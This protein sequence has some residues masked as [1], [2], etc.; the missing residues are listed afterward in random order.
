MDDRLEFVTRLGIGSSLILLIGLM[1]IA[2]CRRQSAATQ[3]WLGVWTCIALLILPLAVALLPSW[4]A[5]ILGLSVHV[6]NSGPNP[7]FSTIEPAAV[8]LHQ[9]GN[10]PRSTEVA[11]SPPEDRMYSEV[12]STFLGQA[13]GENFIAQQL[14][15]RA[16]TI[17]QA[18]TRTSITLAKPVAQSLLLAYLL[19][20]GLGILRLFLAHNAVRKWIYRSV[21]ISSEATRIVEECHGAMGL[22]RR[23]AVRQSRQIAVPVVVGLLHP[24]ILLPK[25]A[26]CW[27]DDRLRAALTHELSHVQRGDL[28]TQ[29]VIQIVTLIYWPQPLVH[30]L[31]LGLRTRREV[32]CDDRVIEC[33]RSPIQYARHLLE[34]AAELNGKQSSHVA[35]LAMARAN[36]IESRIMVILSS[37]RRR[38]PPTRKVVVVMGSLTILGTLVM[39]SASP[40]AF[41]AAHGLNY[42][43]AA[44]QGSS[45]NKARHTVRGRVMLGKNRPAAG[46]RIRN[47]P[48][49]ESYPKTETKA[50]VNGYYELELPAARYHPPLIAELDGLSG[51]AEVSVDS[52][53]QFRSAEIDAT[54]IVIKAG[55]RIE[56]EVV[57]ET[58]LPVNQAAVYLQA[59]AGV[60]ERLE[61]DAEGKVAFV[62]PEGLRLQTLG[63][64]KSGIGCD[65]YPFEKF[66]VA[67][68]GPL[69]LPKQPQGFEGKIRL[70]L[71]GTREATVKLNG[72]NG[73]PL[74]GVL[75]HPGYSSRRDRDS[76]WVLPWLPEFARETDENGIGRFDMFSIHENGGV[77]VAP[78][79]E[80]KNLYVI[81]NSQGADSAIINWEDGALA[82]IQLAEKILIGGNTR[83]VDGRPAAGIAIRAAGDS[84]N[85]RRFHERVVSDEHGKW[86]MWVKPN[87]YYLFAVHHEEF[88]AVPHSGIVIGE[89]N[90]PKNFD[91]ELQPA[92]RVFGRIPGPPGDLRVILQQ[93]AKKHSS[94]PKHERLPNLEKMNRPITTMIEDSQQLDR[95]GS[96]EFQVGPGDFTILSPGREPHHF[97]ITDQPAVDLGELRR[98]PPHPLGFQSPAELAAQAFESDESLQR[99]FTMLSRQARESNQQLLIIAGAAANQ[100]TVDL[101]GLLKDREVQLALASYRQLP[102]DLAGDDNALSRKFLQT[103]LG[104]EIDTHDTELIVLGND[105]K[106]VA[107]SSISQWQSN[108]DVLRQT[109]IEF[110]HKHQSVVQRTMTIFI[111]DE[112]GK[113]LAN[114]QVFRNHVFE[115]EKD[116][117]HIEDLRLRSDADGKVIVPLSGTS[118]D[119]RLWV[120]LDGFVPLHAMWAKKFQIDGDQVPKEFT[121]RM[122]PGTEIG[123][124]VVN[125]NGQ[126]ISGAI[127][128]VEEPAAGSLAFGLGRDAPALRPVRSSW[129]AAGDTAVATD[130]DGRWLLR[131]VPSDE[132]LNAPELLPSQRPQVPWLTVRV[133]LPGQE[134]EESGF[135]RL[136]REQDISHASLR[137]RSAKFVVSTHDESQ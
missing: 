10:S 3:Y 82:E 64:V 125:E 42:S 75:L 124:I 127:V 122:Q 9:P 48:S 21:R 120:T 79:L 93:H 25:S 51:I 135:G 118:V 40:I 58:Q 72:P 105:Q 130:A 99:R 74:A 28:C 20:L 108:G 86:Q 55:R 126:P 16:P 36:P 50:D 113:P 115:F 54:A 97:A 73:E 89:S 70:L 57:D 87:G 81:G 98:P 18:F 45:E 26:S 8:P 129:L 68:Q 80:S 101:Y 131:N 30:F 22:T 100:S 94:L 32:A 27:P 134:K 71:D 31:S 66:S 65:Y 132:Q 110:A 13:T 60:V 123:G 4:P 107:A 95:D 67:A 63:A 46:A 111:T 112:F 2:I 11:V 15:D 19:G 6:V 5:N 91:F 17:R 62:Y 137:D 128:E 69:F 23:V 38:M 49:G 103:I 44:E 114:A 83:Y 109:L 14:A 136:Q 106:V 92:R 12:P 76:P 78:K 52:S 61:T 7:S 29:L 41:S 43:I 121:F 56:V 37:N 1:A 116:K 90:P 35:T 24:M 59:N 104:R 34:V 102:V 84:T 133:T 33:Y 119:L 117:P 77:G 85:F 88:A 96:F 47:L 53:M 39:A